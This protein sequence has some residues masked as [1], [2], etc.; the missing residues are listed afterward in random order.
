LKH[1]KEK[2]SFF[3]IKVMKREQ[4]EFNFLEL[5]NKKNEVWFLKAKL[6]TR[7]GEKGGSRIG[8]VLPHS[9]E[10]FPHLNG[11]TRTF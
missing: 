8:Y 9:D 7:K 5:C 4:K 6:E 3:M 2:E 11:S 1:I 10:V